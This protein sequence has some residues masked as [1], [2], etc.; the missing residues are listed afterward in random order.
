M[1]KKVKT[2]TVTQGHLMPTDT[3]ECTGY[4]ITKVT[5]SLQYT[6]GDL[7]A[8]NDLHDLCLAR[9]WKVTVLAGH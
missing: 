7:I 9:D 4:R 8:K 1:N 2:I 5:D 6:P 3:T